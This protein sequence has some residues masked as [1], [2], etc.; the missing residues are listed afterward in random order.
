MTVTLTQSSS[1]AINLTAY[2]CDQN[3]SLK[4]FVTPA[5]GPVY[6]PVGSNYTFQVQCY[7]NHNAN[8]NGILGT[9]FS[10]YIIINYS[11]AVS[12]QTSTI[13]AKAVADISSK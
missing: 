8:F 2:T 12:G 11:D 3:A 7:N 5:G 6:L 13:D 1:G 4:N 10:G 9:P